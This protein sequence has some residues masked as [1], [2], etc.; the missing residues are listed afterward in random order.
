MWY[1]EGAILA[2]KNMKQKKDDTLGMPE[3]MMPDRGHRTGLSPKQHSGLPLS[4]LAFSKRTAG[5]VVLAAVLV[6]AAIFIPMYIKNHRT[7]GEAEI[8]KVS[9]QVNRL[10]EGL[11]ADLPYL[12]SDTV[13][14]NFS[15][16]TK[17]QGTGGVRE[18]QVQANSTEVIETYRTYFKTFGWEVVT[19]ASQGGV[20]VLGAAKSGDFMTVSIKRA[21]GVTAGST[22]EV[23]VRRIPDETVAVE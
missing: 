17:D 18:W 12:N 20:S 10:P 23:G 13:I 16:E 4:K 21:A 1:N 7:Q 15:V 9:V 6:V 19:D 11:P 14:H 22:I 8:Q 5:L 3:S 2:G